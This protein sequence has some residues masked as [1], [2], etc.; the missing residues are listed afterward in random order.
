MSTFTVKFSSGDELTLSGEVVDVDSE[1]GVVSLRGG[2]DTYNFLR[3]S[4]VYW[5]MSSDL[6]ERQLEILRLMSA[7]KTNA[8]IARELGYSEST[9]R[10]E[11]MVIYRALGV[12]GREGAAARAAEWGLLGS[13][14]APPSDPPA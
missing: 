8:A 9:V 5:T 4:I 11:T 6:S 2:R 14:T 13:G 3:E 12:D 1:S 7:G 10:Q